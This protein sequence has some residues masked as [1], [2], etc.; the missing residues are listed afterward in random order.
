MCNP[1]VGSSDFCVDPALKDG[2]RGPFILYN[3]A[4]PNTAPLYRCLRAKPAF[5]TISLHA[6]CDGLGTMESLLGYVATQR[7]NETLR[8]RAL[9]ACMPAW[10][11]AACS[12]VP[13]PAWAACPCLLAG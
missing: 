1:I 7:G 9:H 13:V 12:H 2:R 10:F 5:H 8:G 11:D 6:D 3:Q 4:L